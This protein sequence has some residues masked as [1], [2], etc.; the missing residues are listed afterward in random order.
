MRHLGVVFV[1]AASAALG[2]ASTARAA[3]ITSASGPI[4]VNGAEVRIDPA[5]PLKLQP[6]DKVDALQ[7]TV[8]IRSEAGDE[9]S[10]EPGSGLTFQGVDNDIEL[11]F[12]RWG[13][14]TG[15]VSPRT[16]LGVAAAWVEVPEGGA[17][18]RVFVEAPRSAAAT[19]GHFR[20]VDGDV[21]LRYR[22]Y[23]AFLPRAH[24]VTLDV[25]PSRPGSLCF[26]TSQQNQGEVRVQRRVQGGDIIVS[27]PRASQGC[28]EDA[29]GNKTRICNDIRSLKTAKMAIATVF[30]GR[31]PYDATIGP[32]TCAL[33]DNATGAIQVV[34]AAV[35]FEILERAISLT[36][37][38]STLAQ[39][40]FSDVK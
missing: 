36:T 34:F 7:A 32:G 31:P 40:N 29:E 35:E 22:S 3:T 5:Q 4:H 6:N 10:L 25:D 23:S 39:S 20:A 13:A 28:F 26:V 18:T 9:L 14:A 2:F 37:E 1:L 15:F 12:L 17:K 27:V 11:L 33:V 38:F 8:T 21:W 24:S 19:Q 30:A 16:S